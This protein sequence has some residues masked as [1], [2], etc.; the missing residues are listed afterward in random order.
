MREGIMICTIW[1]GEDS[2][3]NFDFYK[4]NL[5][6]AILPSTDSP[7]KPTVCTERLFWVWSEEDKP[8]NT[9]LTKVLLLPQTSFGWNRATPPK[10]FVKP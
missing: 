4:P 3:Q 9:E 8:S 2:Y 10:N 7:M 6:S 5:S 1:P